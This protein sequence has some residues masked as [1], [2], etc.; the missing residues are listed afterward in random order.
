[1][2]PATS[3]LPARSVAAVDVVH[4]SVLVPLAVA[5]VPVGTPRVT[6]TVVPLRARLEA[7]KDRLPVTYFLPEV[8]LPREIW[9]VLVA[10]QIVT[11][12]GLPFVKR[13]TTGVAAP[14]HPAMIDAGSIGS[15]NV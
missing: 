9:V 11:T 13:T 7:V 14:V 5:V 10:S 3:G 15:E 12:S 6:V 2:V 8:K 1:M 4:C